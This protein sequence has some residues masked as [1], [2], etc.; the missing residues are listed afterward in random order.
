VAEAGSLVIGIGNPLRGDDGVGW[1]LLEELEAAEP[2]DGV[3]LRRVQ[4]LTPELAAELSE[5]RRALFVDAWLAPAGAEPLLR[6][7]DGTGAGEG[8]DSHRLEPLTVLALAQH[9]FGSRP[10]AWQLLVPSACFDHGNA[11]S[12][13]LRRGLPPA[14]RLLRRWLSS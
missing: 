3:R 10:A 14:R 2:I 13:C 7:V 5:V 8:I 6:P 12:A 9:L 1:R 4:Q 11:F